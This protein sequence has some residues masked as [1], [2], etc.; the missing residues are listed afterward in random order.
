MSKTLVRQPLMTI[1]LLPAG[2]KKWI[3]T[4]IENDWFSLVGLDA[5]LAWKTEW[6]QTLP[7]PLQPPNSRSPDA[8]FQPRD[9]TD[10]FQTQSHL[11][12]G[13]LR[14]LLGLQVKKWVFRTQF[15]FE[16]DPISGKHLLHLLRRQLP[17]KMSLR[18]P[19]KRRQ[20]HPWLFL[21][22]RSL[23]TSLPSGHW[24]TR[25]LCSR[26]QRCRFALS[27]IGEIVSLSYSQALEHQSILPCLKHCEQEARICETFSQQVSPHYWKMCE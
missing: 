14:N 7:R 9:S 5:A 20:N 6:W 1:S 24:Y 15:C 21:A 22:L 16:T 8:S 19:L 26:W 17:L 12:F 3:Q 25:I 23:L 18:T 2:R 11:M 27:L 13:G 10:R 4:D